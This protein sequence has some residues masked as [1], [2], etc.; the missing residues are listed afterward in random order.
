MRLLLALFSGLGL[1]ALIV[2]VAERVMPS[3]VAV[4]AEVAARPLAI[5]GEPLSAQALWARAAQVAW[6]ALTA[7]AEA[8][9]VEAQFRRGMAHLTGA[10]GPADAAEGRRWLT[11]AAEQG[12]GRAL[13]AL[14]EVL[15]SGEFAE[16]DHPKAIACFQAAWKAGEPMGLVNLGILAET[17]EGRPKDPAEALRCF[18]QAADRGCAAALLR[19]GVIA[20]EG[21]LLPRD[22]GQAVRYFRQAAEKGSKEG[23]LNLAI[24]HQRGQGTPRD[25]AAALTCARQAWDLGMTDAAYL[26]I[27]RLVADGGDPVE[28]GGYLLAVRLLDGSPECREQCERR[29]GPWMD[30]LQGDE[31]LRQVVEV[32][33]RLLAAECRRRLR[34]IF[35]P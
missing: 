17:G 5:P 21:D 34:E 1:A 10:F 27:D 20:S 32:Q 4:P 23:W 15:I 18:R 29:K 2:L 7:K 28:A 35:G 26:V 16:P 31:A 25:R 22:D 30:K 14:G 24:A 33:E 11:R 13:N 3:A 6:P 8:G 12:H 19:L 9:D